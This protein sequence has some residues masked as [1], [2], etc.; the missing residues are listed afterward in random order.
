M[1]V[2]PDKILKI[3]IFWE[4]L[5]KFW[6]TF[7]IWIVILINFVGHDLHTIECE[8]TIHFIIN[9]EKNIWKA[10]YVDTSSLTTQNMWF[11]QSE[12][13]FWIWK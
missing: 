4:N 6:E 1:Y 3:G 2:M 12:S 8:I 10:Y 9:G 7:Q 11:Q 13:D 5:P